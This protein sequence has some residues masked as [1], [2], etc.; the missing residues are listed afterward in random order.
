MAESLN[1]LNVPFEQ[2]DDVADVLL[3]PGSPRIINIDDA[4][5]RW[6][7]STD[8][9]LVFGFHWYHPIG[10]DALR[11]GHHLRVLAS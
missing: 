9:I 8:G 1:G 3:I 7:K 10:C 5:L 6:D 11:I 2:P 4:V